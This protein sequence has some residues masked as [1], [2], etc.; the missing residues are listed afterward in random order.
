MA[1][2]VEDAPRTGPRG[3]GAATG[4]RLAMAKARCAAECLELRQL[5]NVGPAMV[6]DF[7]L[8]GIRHP[9]QLI[10]ADAL[11]LYQALCNATSQR[12]DPCVLDTFMA[13]V[14]FMGG[15]EPRPW[16]AYTAERKK[17]HPTLNWP[18]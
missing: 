5:P 9:Q 7:H 6:G 17:R 2:P 1:A 15:A 13:V 14:D 11:A 12:H 16:F 18:S 10:G 4:R 3:R 8:L